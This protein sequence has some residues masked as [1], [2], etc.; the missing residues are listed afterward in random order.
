LNTSEG[1]SYDPGVFQNL[2]PGRT[3]SFELTRRF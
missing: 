2:L 1:F 3:W